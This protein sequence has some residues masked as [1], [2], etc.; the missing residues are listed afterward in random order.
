MA[1]TSHSAGVRLYHR[2]T[3]L[4]ITSEVV[5]RIICTIYGLRSTVYGLRGAAA[6]LATAGAALCAVAM[7]C[8][9]GWTGWVLLNAGFL[10]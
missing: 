8:V 7:I 9:Q 5:L 6:V 2:R 10:D 3:V 1:A 4:N